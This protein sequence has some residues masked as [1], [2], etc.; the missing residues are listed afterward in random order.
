M[1][2]STSTLGPSAPVNSKW[3]GEQAR[4]AEFAHQTMALP[5]ISLQ[6]IE[7]IR[8][9][10]WRTAPARQIASARGALT[11]ISEL[12]FVLLMPISGT[13]LPSLHTATRND[14]AWW[15]WKQ[16]LPER[17]ACYYAKVLRRRGTFISWDWFPAFYAAYADPRPYWRQYRE[18][19]LDREEKQILDLLDS[20]GPLMTR[21]IRLAFGPRSKENT[22]RVKSILVQL[23]A[24]FLIT[25]AGG[26]TEGWSHHRWDL[27]ER[28]VPSRLLVAATRLAPEKARLWLI[29][30]CVRNLVATTPADI[31]WLFGWKRA[32]VDQLV[33]HLL[34]R[35]RIARALVPE[36]GGE[37]LVCSPWPG[38]ARKARAC[39]RLRR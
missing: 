28:W 21:E 2:P 33:A 3:A 20:R 34:D 4:T 10:R 25:A 1:K 9:H 7:S 18:G 23:Q 31:A 22:R 16:T 29:E 6:E 11:F 38:R 36:L 15:D 13:E 26:D 14:W 5:E 32:E 35:R 37:V 24:R 30:R 27:V 12:C 39:R 19:L 17:K 8:A